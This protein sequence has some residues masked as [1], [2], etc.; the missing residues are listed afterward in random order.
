MR[1]DH[2][3]QMA[4]IGLPVRNPFDWRLTPQEPKDEGPVAR[5][6]RMSRERYRSAQREK[7]AAAVVKSMKG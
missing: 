3:E 7:R 4:A 2:D 5:N 6:K 1:L